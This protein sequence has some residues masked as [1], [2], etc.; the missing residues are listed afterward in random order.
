M[1]IHALG[2]YLAIKRSRILSFA[3]IWMELEDIML[4][5]MSEAQKDKY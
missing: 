5:E 4:S 3:T 2:Y 1:H